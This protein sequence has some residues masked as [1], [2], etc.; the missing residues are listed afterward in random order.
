MTSPV[1]TPLPC[2][3]AALSAPT[4]APEFSPTDLRLPISDLPLPV[5]APS[6]FEIRHSP[7]TDRISQHHYDLALAEIERLQNRLDELKIAATRCV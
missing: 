5:P 2:E 3:S 7:F 4:S 1:E 6:S